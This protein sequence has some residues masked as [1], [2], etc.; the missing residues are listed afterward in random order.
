VDVEAT[1][2]IVTDTT[3]RTPS[4][5]ALPFSTTDADTHVVRPAP[6]ARDTKNDT[7]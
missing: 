7:E 1:A 2:S 5:V 3:R 4:A 6:L